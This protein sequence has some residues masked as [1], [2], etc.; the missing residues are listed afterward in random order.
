MEKADLKF[1]LYRVPWAPA[2][3]VLLVFIGGRAMRKQDRIANQESRSQETDKS[4]QSESQDRERMRGSS[5]ESER[6]NEGWRL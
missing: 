2:L 6:A 4:N 1:G 5:R 3:Q